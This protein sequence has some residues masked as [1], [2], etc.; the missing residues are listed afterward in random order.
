MDSEKTEKVST[1]LPKE[2][3]NRLKR[4]AIKRK[5]PYHTVHRE[6]IEWFFR[7]IDLNKDVHEVIGI[8]DMLDEIELFEFMTVCVQIARKNWKEWSSDIVSS[9]SFRDVLLKTIA[10]VRGG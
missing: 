10:K 7:L 4:L 1:V 9:E 3:A 8:D 2:I 5:E 6:A